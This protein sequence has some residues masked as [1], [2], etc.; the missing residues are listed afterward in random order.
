MPSRVAQTGPANPPAARRMKARTRVV[1]CRQYPTF[2]LM[3][4]GASYAL[5]I[6]TKAR[7][8]GSAGMKRLFGVKSGRRSLPWKHCGGEPQTLA[9]GERSILVS[10]GIS[11]TKRSTDLLLQLS[12]ETTAA[13][14][15][16]RRR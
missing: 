9:D 14:F 16:R 2:G 10:E 6:S 3:S 4:R 15:Q 12:K 11:D 13:L 1:T 5:P 7:S 8:S